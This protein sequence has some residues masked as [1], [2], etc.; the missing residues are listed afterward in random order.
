M[1]QRPPTSREK[2]KELSKRLD[3]YD[4]QK[5]EGPERPRLRPV[6]RPKAGMSKVA[7]V[8]WLCFV[9]AC[10]LGVIAI[11]IGAM[12]GIIGI[13]GALP[14]W[15]EVVEQ[16][17]L[18]L[19]FSLGLVIFYKFANRTPRAP[20]DADDRQAPIAPAG[21]QP[22]PSLTFAP[23]RATKIALRVMGWAFGLFWVFWIILAWH[24]RPPQAAADW[25]V[26]PFSAGLVWLIYQGHRF[27]LIQMVRAMSG[28][29]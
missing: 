17:F 8:L 29:H 15:G 11:Q 26:F 12:T 14:T 25:L 5:Q 2:L 16:V 10:N 19:L 7:L 1:S 20:R 13:E 18:G 4:R 24:A 21:G 9:W 22:A 28:R 27:I 6:E 23:G 3:D